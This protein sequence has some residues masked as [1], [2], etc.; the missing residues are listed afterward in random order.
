MNEKNKIICLETC[1]KL[2][3][4][5]PVKECRY[6][7]SFSKEYNCVHESVYRNGAMTLR[8]AAER[9]NISYVRVKQIQDKAMKKI[10]HLFEQ[11]PI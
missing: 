11:E 4:A 5:C 3:V 2:D 6:W 8:Q 10:G 9:L 1:R 7:V